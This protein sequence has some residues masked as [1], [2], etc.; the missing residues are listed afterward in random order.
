MTM[1]NVDDVS[2]SYGKTNAVSNVSMAIEEGEIVGIIGPNGAG[3]T[4]LFN[5]VTG[6]DAPD[7][8]SVRLHGEELVGARPN[9]VCRAGLARTFQSVRTFDES[10]VRENVFAGA[11]FGGG[12][13]EDAA[14]RA[15]TAALELVDLA[16]DADRHASDLPIAARKRVELARALATDPDVL[17]LDEIGSGLTPVEIDALTE[18]I[19]RI[20]DDRGVAVVWIE[21]VTDALFDGA[22]RVLVLDDGALIAEGT[23]AEIRADDR[24]AEAYLGGGPERSADPTATTESTAR[25]EPAAEPAAEPTGEPTAE[26]TG[27]PTAEPADSQSV[28]PSQPS[29]ATPR[30][31]AAATGRRGAASAATD[32]GEGDTGTAT[33]P[34]Q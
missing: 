16:G 20:R 26:P 24:V 2:I 9:T 17:L 4:T 21:H 19:V 10:T 1:L 33:E 29:T 25:T 18:T 13:D 6:V 8:G 27:E 22:D 11:R 3:K 30:G 31:S 32:G 23:P 7:S 15:T 28:A 34:S 5:A 12:H 14:A